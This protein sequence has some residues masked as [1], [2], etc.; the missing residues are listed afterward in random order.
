MTVNYDV[1]KTYENMRATA[2]TDASKLGWTTAE[3]QQQNFTLLTGML[4]DLRIPLPGLRLHDAGCGTGD[5]L[6]FLKQKEMEPRQYIGTDFTQA[7]LEIAKSRFPSHDFL[8]MDLLPYGYKPPM[9][10]QADVTLVFGALAYHK[11]RDV[12]AMLNNLWYHSTV[13]LGFN[14]WW[15]LHEGY[16]YHE[17]IE[18]LRKCIN[19][20]LRNK[21]VHRKLGDEYGQPTEA[22]FV[23]YR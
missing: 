11:P 4:Q 7:S 15:Q 3:L 20:F 23:V 18:Q 21:Q 6:A 13:A 22:L 2:D 8:Q 14:T 12:E 19:R 16:V 10:P 9:M 5:L 17:S 1:A